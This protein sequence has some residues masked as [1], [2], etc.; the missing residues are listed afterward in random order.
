MRK[1]LISA[2]LAAVMLGAQAAQAADCT[3]QRLGQVY[4]AQV[5]ISHPAGRIWIYSG[6]GAPMLRL[7]G[8][9]LELMPLT[10]ETASALATGFAVCDNVV[11][12]LDALAAVQAD[13]NRCAGVSRQGTFA[14]QDR[15]NGC[16]ASAS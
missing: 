3:I 14:G 8:T 16:D 2:A 4:H 12:V 15:V 9:K 11:D 1:L 13:Y 5:E 7:T 6:G 10:Y